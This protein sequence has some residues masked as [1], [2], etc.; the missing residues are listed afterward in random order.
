MKSTLAFGGDC[1]DGGSSD[2]RIHFHFLCL[3][4]YGGCINIE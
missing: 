2:F 1:V 3:F 4:M